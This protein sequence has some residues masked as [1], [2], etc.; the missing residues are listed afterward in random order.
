[1]MPYRTH[2]LALLLLAVTALQGQEDSLDRN[3][4]P[5]ATIPLVTLSASDLEA[6]EESQDIS[7]L[8][9][10]SRDIF[11]STAGYTFGSARFRVRGYDSENM[12]VMINGMPVNDRESG[13]AFWSG[14]GGLNDVTRYQ[15]IN[16]NISSGQHHFGGI[17][18]STNMDTRASGFRK[19]SQ[20]TYSLANRSYRNRLMFTSNTGMMKNGWAFTVSGSRR[21]AQEGYVEGTFYDA[22]SYFV[23]AE[24]KINDKHSLVFTGFGSPTISGRPGVATQEAYDLAGTN[25][26]NPYWGYQNGEKRNARV[27]HYHQ[28]MLILGHYWKLNPKTQVNQAVSYTFGRGGG[29]ALEWYDAA[30][31]RP[32]YYRNL[33]SYYQVEY[34]EQFAYYTRQWEEN[35]TF[36]QLDWDQFYFANGKNLYTVQNANGI[37]GNNITGNRAKYIVE[38]RRND[39][40]HLMYNANL[41]HSLSD[42]VM[43]SAGLNLS[44][45][46]GH[47]YKVVDDLLG[48]DFWV[49]VDKYAERDFQDPVSANSDIR[50]PNRVVK[51]GDIFGYDYDANINQADVFAM[52]ET[53]GRRIDLY[54]A[55]QGSSTNF[56]RT[57]NMQNGK[58]PDQ[59]LGDGEKHSFLNYGIKAGADYKIT[60]RHFI[61]ANLMYM[62]RA[63]YF[64]NAYISSRTRDQ[65]VEGLDN[66]QIQGGDISYLFRGSRLKLRLTGYYT[67]FNDGIWAR[68]FYHEELNS[69]VNYVMNGVDQIRTGIEFGVEANL[70]PTITASLVVAE[71]DYIYN[72]RPEVF[73][74]QDNNPEEIIASR[75]VYLKNYKV[76]GMP[77]TAIS[78]G[79]KYNSPKFWFVGVNLSYYDNIYLTPNPDRRT[80][81]AI[82]GLVTDDVIYKQLLAQ[83]KLESG[84]VT[85]LFGGKSW[86]FGDHFISLTLSMN[87]LLDVTDFAIGGF[88]Q[89]RYDARDIDRFPPKYFYLYGRSYFVNIRYR[90]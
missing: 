12:T 70:T 36:R 72:S 90:F 62:T 20:V 33:P 4:L 10:A 28:P 21:W 51:E 29:T 39:K 40:Q 41:R 25:Y 42:K 45:F 15:E 43:I 75:E 61:T 23:S 22:W 80:E 83:E 87:N 71:G 46:K 11:T 48:A 81:D 57:G 64:R 60:G 56:W 18:G 76:G 68:S 86:R 8:L 44:Q 73:I 17:G 35:E 38:Q 88:E 3:L 69:F 9:Q 7:G 31:P 65:V 6:D 16:T 47:N 52:I 1:M 24:K 77:E 14:W 59:S 54:A 78:G 55:L 50:T 66:E 84:M 49:D 79:L 82:Q 85:D 26:Y 13:R 19:G 32:D 5:N 63:P 74:A 2:I 30:D 27:N 67:E 89:Y 37:E 53:K 34:P 58:F